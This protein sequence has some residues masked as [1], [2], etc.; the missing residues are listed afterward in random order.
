MSSFRLLP[1]RHLVPLWVCFFAAVLIA[2]GFFEV[3]SIVSQASRLRPLP[4]FRCR[5]FLLRGRFFLGVVQGSGGV[6]F[7]HTRGGFGSRDVA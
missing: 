3:I 2:G 6:G 5:L 4:R 7:V 1:P